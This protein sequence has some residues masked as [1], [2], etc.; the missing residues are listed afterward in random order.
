VVMTFSSLAEAGGTQL[1]AATTDYETLLDALIFNNASDQFTD[2][3]TRSFDVMAN[4]GFADS[5]VAT[6]T[7]TLDALK[8]SVLLGTDI[9]DA[10]DGL[11]G[12]D[13]LV[14]GDGDDTLIGSEGD[15][16]I[17]GVAG[18][19]NIRGEEGDDIA[20]GGSGDD[21]Y[22]FD[23]DEENAD[24]Q[25]IFVGG[26][27]LD[28]VQF[29]EVGSSYQISLV[30]SEQRDFLNALIITDSE[31]F[32]DVA[33][34]E[35]FSS[36][37]PIYFI[38]KT[39]PTIDGSLYQ[40]GFMQAEYLQFSDVTL[41]FSSDGSPQIVATDSSAPLNYDGLS[42][43]NPIWMP[44][45]VAGG[46][47][48]DRLISGSDDDTLN[49][50]AGDDIL[51]SRAGS[52]Q[53]FG[54]EG[55]DIFAVLATDVASQTDRSVSINGGAGSDSFFLK[56][57]DGSNSLDFTVEDFVVGEDVIDFEGIYK[58]GETAGAVEPITVSDILGADAIDLTDQQLI[59]NFSDFLSEDGDVLEDVSVTLNL[60]ESIAEDAIESIFPINGSI[61]NELS[62][63]WWHT[64]LSE[65]GD[66]V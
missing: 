56:Y 58:T 14:G 65:S 40:S 31:R 54:G 24:F 10:L 34:S 49:G 44:L 23:I 27:G 1:A 32:R 16:Y 66:Q 36:S 47:V 39:D 13:A 11:G 21:I 20:D 60:S 55:N 25:D 18:N 2:R 46:S 43:E 4:D 22:S 52:D 6:I 59:I 17:L 61:A 57:T 29:A 9:A 48:S 50:K 5:N 28:T 53:L 38:Q 41:Q 45:N 12:D 3:S 19:D 33:A 63:D 7:V 35:G 15:D 30:G 26:S 64:L 51:V 42:D 62:G 8:D 37:E